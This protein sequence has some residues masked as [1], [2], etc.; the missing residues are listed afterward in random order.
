MQ[1]VKEGAIYFRSFGMIHDPTYFIH[2]VTKYW[3]GLSEDEQEEVLTTMNDI[4]DRPP[5]DPYSANIVS[6][7]NMFKEYVKDTSQ[8]KPTYKRYV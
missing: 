1:G 5:I 6:N 3:D 2:N 4:V 8:K 7:W